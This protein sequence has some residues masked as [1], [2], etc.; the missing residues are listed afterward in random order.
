MEENRIRQMTLRISEEFYDETKKE[1]DKIGSSYNS[2]LLMLMSLGMK[3]YSSD[4]IILR[5]L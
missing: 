4:E 2:F 1:A 3:I 5:Q